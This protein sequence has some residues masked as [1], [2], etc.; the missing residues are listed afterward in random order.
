MAVEL[1]KALG[2]KVIA[3]ASSDEKLEVCKKVGADYVVNYSKQKLKDEVGK[4]TNGEFCDVIYDPVGGDIFNECV[5]CVATKGYA[6]LLVIGFASGTIP[7]FAVNMALIKGFD[8]VGVRMG[9]QLGID[10]NLGKR[11]MSDLLKMAAD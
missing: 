9:A 3:A 10:P 7:K 5:R 11:T 6:G 4:I 2:A 1:G 8:L